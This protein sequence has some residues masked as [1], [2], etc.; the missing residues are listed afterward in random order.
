MARRLASRDAAALGADAAG[1]HTTDVPTVPAGR[2]VNTL[3]P[4]THS[5]A[6]AEFH[7]RGVCPFLDRPVEV[8]CEKV[9]ATRPC[10]EELQCVYPGCVALPCALFRWWVPPTRHGECSVVGGASN[11][12]RRA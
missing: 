7:F 11:V 10:I 3:H 8:T 9:F 5:A 1:T 4:G 12:P 2:A 6:Y